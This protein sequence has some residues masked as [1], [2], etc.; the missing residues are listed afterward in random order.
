MIVRILA[1]QLPNIADKRGR[2]YNE[3]CSDCH[4]LFLQM[5]LNLRLC[6]SSVVKSFYKT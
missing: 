6:N 5:L 4:C 1:V 2:N 3:T